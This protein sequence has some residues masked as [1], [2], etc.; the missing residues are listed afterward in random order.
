MRFIFRI[1]LLA[2]VFVA[3]WLVAK[4]GI[5]AATSQASLPTLEREFSERMRDVVLVGRFT[6][7]GRED[8]GGQPDRYE[9]STVEKVG[10]DRWRFNARLQYGNVDVTLPITLPMRWVDD[11]PMIT[12]TDVSLPALGT[13]TARVFFYGDR[14]SGTWQHGAVG[15]HLF[16]RIE[17]AKSR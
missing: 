2:I 14:Y 9:I 17:K 5:G 6:V 1:L 15:C 13:F 4:T 16:G 10:T 3:G 11:T 12:M 7:A 8:Q